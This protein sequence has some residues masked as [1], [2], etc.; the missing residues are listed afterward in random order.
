MDDLRYPVGA[1]VAPPTPLS[2]ARRADLI[3]V[4]E[5]APAGLRQAVAGLSEAQLD[6]P[7]RPQG[8]TVRQVVHHVPDSHV[9]AYVRFGLALT[10][11]E[12]TVKPYAED[13]WARLPEVETTPIEASLELLE[14]V[15]RRWVIRLR[16]ISPTEWGRRLKHPDLG[17]VDLDWV[18][19][20]YAWHGRHHTGHV[21]ALRRREGWS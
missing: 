14:A 2:E 15:H 10:E 7:Y 11:D 13:R 9:N 12:P 16:G 5:G 8:W 3:R 4:I 19:A 20:Q 17:V 6:T 21:L 18:L 1:F